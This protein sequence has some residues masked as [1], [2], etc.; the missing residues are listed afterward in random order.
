M[1]LRYQKGLI[2]L[3]VNHHTLKFA[4]ADRYKDW[5]RRREYP[6]VNQLM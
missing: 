2:I 6:L 4:S 5:K 1:I 3:Q